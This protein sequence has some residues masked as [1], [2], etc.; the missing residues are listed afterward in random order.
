VRKTIGKLVAAGAIGAAA[1]GL[2]AVPAM[3]QGPAA[4]DGLLVDYKNSA[5]TIVGQAH[6]QLVSAPDKWDIAVA[7]KSTTD[8]KVPCVKIFATNGN[9]PT[10]CDRNGTSAAAHFT[11]YYDWE[12]AAFG[13][14]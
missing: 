2:L 3:A 7:D 11:I 5:G 9:A 4:F 13:L 14:A 1:T 6:L 12:D 10:Y 8:G